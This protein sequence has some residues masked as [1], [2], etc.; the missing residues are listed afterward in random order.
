M[1]LARHGQPRSFS[2]GEAAEALLRVL[3]ECRPQL[4]EFR[5]T[6]LRDVTWFRRQGLA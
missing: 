1:G 5:A 6:L 2:R 3:E 4:A